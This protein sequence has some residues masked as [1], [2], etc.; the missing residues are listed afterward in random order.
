MDTILCNFSY[1]IY[2]LELLSF[3]FKTGFIFGSRFKI[4]D[5]DDEWS[6][7]IIWF[8]IGILVVIIDD[9]IPGLFKLNLLVIILAE[10]SF[11][12]IGKVLI[13]V[14]FKLFDN[15]GLKFNK[16]SLYC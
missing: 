10:L 7:R 5:L 4:L 14:W 8:F 2:S 3:S 1:S 11:K 9:R 15:F 12:I 16:S 13:F 6:V